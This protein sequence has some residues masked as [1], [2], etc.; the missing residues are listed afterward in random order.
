MADSEREIPRPLPDTPFV[1]LTEAVTWIALDDCQTEDDFVAA[2]QREANANR[3]AWWSAEGPEWLVW[4]L[5]LISANKQP[6]L[7]SHSSMDAELVLKA[8]EAAKRWLEDSGLSA[9]DALERIDGW[10]EAQPEPMLPRL[11]RVQSKIWQACAAEEMALEGRRIDPEMGRIAGQHDTIPWRFFLRPV[12][13]WLGRG[14]HGRGE[15]SPDTTDNSIEAILDKDDDRACYLE[16]LMR[17]Q[18]VL[19]IKMELESGNPIRQKAAKGK[20]GAKPRY[21]WAAARQYLHECLDE[22]GDVDPDDLDGWTSQA[23]MERVLLDWFSKRNPDRVPA[24]STIRE[25]VKAFHK[26][27]LAG[28]AGN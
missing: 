12:F 22:N 28:F 23:D 21:D 1:T 15:L 20:P 24:T 7:D 2:A 16:V 18:D 6:E 17:R 3:A 10:L 26:E 9:E 19:R 11:Q 4:H 5:Q 13:H 25:R 27:W 8:F 14:Y